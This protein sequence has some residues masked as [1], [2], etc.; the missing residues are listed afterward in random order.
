VRIHPLSYY[1]ASKQSFADLISLSIFIFPSSTLDATP[2]LQLVHLGT[3][4]LQIVPGRVSTEVDA[5]LSFDKEAT[6]A[7]ELIALYDSVGVKKKRVLI[8]IASTWEGIHCNLTLLFGF[9]QAVACAEAGIALISPFFERVSNRV[10]S[11]RWNCITDRHLSSRSSTGTRRTS[12]ARTMSARRT[13]VSSPFS[14][15]ST[16][17]SST[18]TRPL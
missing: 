4:I 2:Y 12:P 18:A 6:K 14:A 8:K 16:T 13:L 15:S 3:E 11:R 10:P 17:T 9:E 7:K 1:V 5:R